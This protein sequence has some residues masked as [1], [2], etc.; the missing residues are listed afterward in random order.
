MMLLLNKAMIRN[1]K[2]KVLIGEGFL[3]QDLQRERKNR[4][5]VILGFL[6]IPTA[7][8][9]RRMSPALEKYGHVTIFSPL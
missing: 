4:D 3:N 5:F 9:V 7:S 1:K 2:K 6:Y 8:G